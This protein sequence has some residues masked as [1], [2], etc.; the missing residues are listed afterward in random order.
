MKPRIK[1]TKLRNLN[2][3]LKG[4]VEGTTTCQEWQG[5]E[6]DWVEGELE[7]V[8]KLLRKDILEIE[9]GI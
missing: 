4:L 3:I 6:R 2:R 9:N 1:E 7:L 8:I 5:E